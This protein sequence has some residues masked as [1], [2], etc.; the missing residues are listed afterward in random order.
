[1]KA[2]DLLTKNNYPSILI[3]GPAGTGKTALVSQAPNSYMFDFDSGMRTAAILDDRFR[4]ARLSCEF[5]IYDEPL[6]SAP[7]MWMKA[8]QKIQDFSKQSAATGIIKHD[9]E[10]IDTIIIDSLSGMAKS[11]HLQIMAMDG[12]PFK[13]ALIQHWGSMV[14]EM[15]KALTI[16]RSIKVLLLVTAHETSDEVDGLNLIRPMSITEKHGRNKLAWLFDEVLHMKMVPKGMG[17]YNHMV[18]GQ[19]TQSIMARTRSKIT[20]DIDTQDIGLIELLKMIG[21]NRKEL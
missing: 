21:Y 8:V 16:L 9:G 6:P 12:D 17:K 14:N 10:V 20:G 11:I 4:T 5:D 1:M 15:E 13:K 18:T 19:S 3:Y 2:S 7:K